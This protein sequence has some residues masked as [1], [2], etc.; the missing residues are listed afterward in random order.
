MRCESERDGTG[1]RSDVEPMTVDIVE[2]CIEM[3]AGPEFATDVA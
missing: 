3:G 2:P 1:T